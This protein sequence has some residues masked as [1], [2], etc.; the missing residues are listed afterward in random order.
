MNKVQHIRWCIA[1]CPVT[2]AERTIW[3]F[4]SGNKNGSVFE[5]TYKYN[6]IGVQLRG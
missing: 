6:F 4:L 1:Q 3:G 5:A 2:N